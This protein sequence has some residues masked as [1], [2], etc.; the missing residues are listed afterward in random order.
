MNEEVGTTAPTTTWTLRLQRLRTPPFGRHGRELIS[1]E[2]MAAR[3]TNEHSANAL[4]NHKYSTIRAKDQAPANLRPDAPLI[5]RA[6][7]TWV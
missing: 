6:E 4:C 3:P 7:L 5:G 1:G 2:H